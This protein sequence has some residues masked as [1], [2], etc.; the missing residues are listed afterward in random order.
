MKKTL[1]IGS[2][3]EEYL[4][5]VPHIP[6]H[7]E[8]LTGVYRG[9][10]IGGSAFNVY[11]ALRYANAPADLL[12]P[13]GHGMHSQ[14]IRNEFVKL[15]IPQ[16]IQANQMDN[17]WNLV[18]NEPNGNRSIIRFTGLDK[19]WQDTWLEAIDISSYHYFYISG[20]DLINYKSA[21]LILDVLAQRRVGSYIIFDASSQISHIKPTIIKRLLQPGILITTNQAEMQRLLPSNDSMQS[22]A[23]RLFQLTRQPV[24]V[25]LGKRGT[26]YY[27]GQKG[28]IAAAPA[29]HAVNINGAG[30]THRGG[31]IASLVNGESIGQAVIMANQLASLVVQQT[32]SSLL[33]DRINNV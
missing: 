10:S 18:L 24:I 6:T 28:Q 31:L 2:V 13:L 30:D 14:R 25:T 23:A 5:D 19:Q 4:I 32:A 3:F 15:K 16:L 1:V 27:D 26:Y 8:K 33:I 11:G 22:K 29:V 20:I 21:S 9:R 17:G 7:G 12:V